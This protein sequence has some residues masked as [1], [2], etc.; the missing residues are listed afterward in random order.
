MFQDTIL[1]VSNQTLFDKP[2]VVTCVAHRFLVVEQLAEIGVKAD[3]LLEPARRDS[4]PAIVAGAVFARRRTTNA[5]VLALASDHVVTD[6]AAFVAACR[7]ASR[8]A[9]EGR[10]VTFGIQPT[11]PATEYGYLSPGDMIVPP[12]RSVRQFIEK[13]DAATAARYIEAG[14]LW[15]SGNF[16]FQ[17]DIMLGEYKA[18]DPASLATVTRAIENAATESPFIRLD[19]DSFESATPISIDYAVM[20]R[21]D[22]AAVVP[23]SCGWSD[24]GTW[25]AVW[26]FSVRNDDG[27]AARGAAIF[28]NSRNCLVISETTVVA[29]N[30]VTDLAVIVTD[31]AILVSRRQDA[32]GLKKLVSTLG[33]AA[34]RTVDQHSAA[35]DEPERQ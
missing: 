29:L 10:I 11:G 22:R 3:I 18:A 13:P 20:E 21:T 16:I 6:V 14:Y 8:A 5:V 28:E 1:R 17:A 33:A 24:I 2:I 4:G 23:V 34:S 31:D 12:M 32:N 35:H 26:E 25:Q 27:N 7:T 15:N 30:D 19:R 9:A